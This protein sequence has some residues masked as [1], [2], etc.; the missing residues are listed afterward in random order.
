VI[1][2]IKNTKT[3]EIHVHN[4]SH[5]DQEIEDDITTVPPN[6]Q[7]IKLFSPKEIKEETGFLNI[8]K[9]HGIDKITPK[10]MKELP[11][12]GLVMLTYIYNAMLRLS[13]WPKQLKTAVIILIPKPGKDPKE[14]SSYRPISLLSII[15]KL[16]ESVEITWDFKAQRACVIAHLSGTN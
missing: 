12:K 10:M 13:F 3:L 2:A 11:K 7:T 14:L 5:P 16:F 8:K 1:L 4:G 6:I 9:A 15:N